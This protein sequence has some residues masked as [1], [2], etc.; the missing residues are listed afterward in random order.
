[1]RHFWPCQETAQADYERLR[2]QALTGVRVPDLVTVRFERFGLAGLIA[3]P[4]AKAIWMADVIGAR[5]PPWTPHLDPRLE[6]LADG[7]EAVLA[8]LVTTTCQ[9]AEVQP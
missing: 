1:M 6:A 5:R 9:I 2:E 4:S 7:Y 8:S 3:R